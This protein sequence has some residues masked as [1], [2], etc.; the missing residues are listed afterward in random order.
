[1]GRA[2]AE[3]PHTVPSSRTLGSSELTTPAFG[4]ARNRG[5]CAGLGRGAHEDPRL[6]TTPPLSQKGPQGPSLRP[7]SGRRRLKPRPGSRGGCRGQRPALV[8][9]LLLRRHPLCLCWGA[10]LQVPPQEAFP[11]APPTP[12]AQAP[13]PSQA[14]PS[15]LAGEPPGARRALSGTPQ[16]HRSDPG[17]AAPPENTVSC[18]HSAPAQQRPR[19]QGAEADAAVGVGAG[20][21]THGE[22]AELQSEL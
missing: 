2:T 11:R 6:P 4:P 12:P 3:V 14:R 9:L 5:P 21:G 19:S 1:M 22:P 8:R 17:S 13:G 10:V 15:L 18:P 20:V 16:T 7:G